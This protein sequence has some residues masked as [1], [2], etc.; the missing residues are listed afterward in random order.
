M[1]FV[2]VRY[3]SRDRQ[4]RLMT[5][6]PTSPMEDGAMYLLAEA[7]ADDF[8]PFDEAELERNNVRQ[9]AQH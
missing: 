6:E 5:L 9:A 4:F 2:R 3:D 7:P 1:R 8:A